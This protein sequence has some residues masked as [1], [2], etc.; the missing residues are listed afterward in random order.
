VQSALLE[1]MQEKQV[2]I[3]NESFV[4][5]EPFLVL[6]T[7]NPIEQEGTYPLPE[8]QTDRFLLKV[9]IGYPSM[10]EER[11]IVR[12]NLNDEVIQVPRV[13]TL[14]ALKNA[15]EAVKKVYLDEKIEQYILDLVFA[16]RQPGSYGLERLTPMLAFGASPRASVALAKASR[17]RAFIHGRAYVTP[18]DVK[19]MAPDVLRHRIGLTFE[20]EAEQVN[21]DDLIQL[22]LNS[23]VI[24]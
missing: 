21:Q 18:D 5:D 15:R 17:A 6:A 9:K 22:L 16:T 19:I 10:E 20:A 7:Q 4:L 8:A 3:G 2:T 1:A 11:L 14:A 24:N 12:R 13:V 23:I